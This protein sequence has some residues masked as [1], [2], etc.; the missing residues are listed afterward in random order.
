MSLS[1][2]CCV[3]S[4]IGPCDVPITHPEGSYLGVVSKCDLKTST[5]RR[6]IPTYRNLIGPMTGTLNTVMKLTLANPCIIIQ[7]K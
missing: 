5:T 7:F 2:E 6:P 4:R 1:C 3:L